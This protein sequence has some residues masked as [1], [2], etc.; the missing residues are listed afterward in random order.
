MINHLVEQE[1]AR[2]TGFKKLS[3]GNHKQKIFRHVSHVLFHSLD[4]Q[5]HLS[6]YSIFLKWKR[7][8]CVQ[9]PI[10]NL[11]YI[12][13]QLIL[14]IEK[15]PFTITELFLK[16]ERFISAAQALIH[17]IVSTAHLT[18]ESS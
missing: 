18:R 13:K 8:A 10:K 6:K 17:G 12:R 15:L 7:V 3:Y 4:F 14:V 9:N 11:V 16:G 1:S 5:L 2:E